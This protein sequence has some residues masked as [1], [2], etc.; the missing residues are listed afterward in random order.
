[1]G[2]TRRHYELY[3]ALNEFMKIPENKYSLSDL[4]ALQTAVACNVR[5]KRANVLRKKM[6]KLAEGKADWFVNGIN[7]LNS[8]PV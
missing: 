6:G 8:Y 5:E 2:M 7:K 1:M 3:P 4:L